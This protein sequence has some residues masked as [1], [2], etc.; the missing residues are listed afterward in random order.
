MI[1]NKDVW[2]KNW[3]SVAASTILK[4]FIL[5][6]CLTYKI[7]GFFVCLFNGLILVC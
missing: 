3:K 6:E 4:F 5:L 2:C 1:P 7:F